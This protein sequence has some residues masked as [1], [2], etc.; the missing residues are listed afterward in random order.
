MEASSVEDVLAARP[1]LAATVGAARA[2]AVAGGGSATTAPEVG[3]QMSA[4]RAAMVG[5]KLLQQLHRQARQAVETTLPVSLQGMLR[6]QARH[7]TGLGLGM[8]L[9]TGSAG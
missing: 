5:R 4:R 8:P 9:A 2:R 3:S 6:G 7:G 1:A